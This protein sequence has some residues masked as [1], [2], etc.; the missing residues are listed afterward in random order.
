MDFYGI[1]GNVLNTI[2]KANVSLSVVSCQDTM[3]FMFKVKPMGN[4]S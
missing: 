3:H 2:E 1:L 4:M